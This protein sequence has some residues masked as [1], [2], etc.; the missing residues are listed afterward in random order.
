MITTRFPM[1]T[2]AFICRLRTPSSVAH[3]RY[4][5]YLERDPEEA[6][7]GASTARPNSL[8]GFRAS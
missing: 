3:A 6:S 7:I 5:D 8:E 2:Y 4:A 1:K